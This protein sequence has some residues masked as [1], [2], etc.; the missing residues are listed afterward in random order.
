MLVRGR[1]DALRRGDGGGERADGERADGER[2]DGERADGP[3]GL[4]GLRVEALPEVLPAALVVVVDCTVK[5][6]WKKN[7]LRGLINRPSL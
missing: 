2:A 3:D 7:S 6:T 5:K 4:G 1:V